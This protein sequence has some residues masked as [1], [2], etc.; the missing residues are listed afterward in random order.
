M[1]VG[2]RKQCFGFERTPSR[3]RVWRQLIE[4]RVKAEPRVGFELG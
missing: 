3:A 4:V 1:R 2:W